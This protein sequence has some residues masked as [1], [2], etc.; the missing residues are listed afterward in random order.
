MSFEKAVKQGL[1]GE[2]CKSGSVADCLVNIEGVTHKHYIKEELQVFLRVSGFEV[3]EV[4]KVEYGWHTEF[5]R[6]PRW[7]K[8]P[9]PW[10]W[11]A[12]CRVKQTG[13]KT[14]QK[15]QQARHCLRSFAVKAHTKEGRFF[16]LAEFCPA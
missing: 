3:M 14:G 2:H 4:G 5:E 9:F 7:M 1:A 12:L 11:M 16:L 13:K 8:E 15:N 10:D 6:P